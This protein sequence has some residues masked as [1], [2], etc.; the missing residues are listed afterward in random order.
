MRAN[1]TS[2]LIS[3]IDEVE[4]LKELHFGKAAKKE[5]HA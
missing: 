4:G 3:F 1:G 5:H 2:P